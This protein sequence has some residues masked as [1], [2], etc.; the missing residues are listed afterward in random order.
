MVE[1]LFETGRV[2]AIKR[3]NKAT[4]EAYQFGAASAGPFVLFNYRDGYRD[5]VLPM[6]LLTH[7]LGHAC[8]RL[9]AEET[10]EPLLLA[11]P[12]KQLSEVPSRLHEFLLTDYL[13]DVSEDTEFQMRV[14]QV[15]EQR[16]KQ[17]LY[18][19]GANLEFIDT[20][21]SL[22]A[23]NKSPTGDELDAEYRSI[24][25]EYM[26]PVEL[27]DYSA[28]GWMTSKLYVEPYRLFENVLG[29]VV[30]A[31]LVSHV[32]S[33]PSTFTEFLSTGL[34]STSKQH[35]DRL[36]TDLSDPTAVSATV[37]RYQDYVDSIS[38][39]IEAH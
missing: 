32:R 19:S 31:D 10:P 23:E 25:E 11:R 21:H 4:V 13:L 28:S 8:A 14:L 9:F 12:N 6:F 22:V 37:T 34:R 7:Q 27:G 24:L 36:P 33:N 3:D 35:L 17:E 16:L 5:F 2:D 18:L 26:S 39:L 30:A 29:V 20:V 1:Q 15:A 38:V